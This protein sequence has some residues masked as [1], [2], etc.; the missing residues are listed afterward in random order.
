MQ[1]AH[2]VADRFPDGQLYLNLRG[3]HPSGKPVPAAA[4]VRGLLESLGVAAERI[5]AGVDA[6]ARLY[7]S[8]LAGRRMLVLLDNAKD[9]EQVRP[10]LPG[11]PGC[12]VLV[13]SRC[14]LS[15]LVAS[16]AGTPPPQARAD[17][18]E[19]ARAHLIS[20]LVPGRYAMHDLLRA[21]AAEQVAAGQVA[22]DQGALDRILDHYLHTA[23]VA[24]LRLRP[25]RDPITLAPPAPAVTI[26]R[27][28]SFQ[29]ALD[30]FDAEHHVLLSAVT[31]AAG[32]GRDACA[33]QL[34]WAMTDFL[35]WRGHWHDWA[36][37]QRVALSAAIR[38]GD[39][40]AE[41]AARLILGQ[42]GARSGNYDQASEHL[43]Q[44]LRLFRQLGDRAG[45][46]RTHQF[47]LYVAEHQARYADALSHA[48][49]ALAH[50]RAILS[51]LGQ[52]AAINDIGWCHA[53]LGDYQRA[54]AR[55]RQALALYRKLGDRRGEAHTWDSLGY[56]EHHLG[57]HAQA[58]V[59][60][61]HALSL[62]RELR[63]RFSEADVLTHLGDARAAVDPVGARD[64]WQQALDIFD[65][66]HHPRNAQVRAKLARTLDLPAWTPP[67]S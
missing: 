28:G 27:I 9:E 55:C 11:S 41:A 45:E 30:W 26:E 65:E 22:A 43:T 39:P 19:L 36:A 5:P 23:R 6:Q 63:D 1:W 59:C 40:A 46:A 33:W 14:Q 54:R 44:C 8:I 64:A 17:L 53:Q 7:R 58:A 31:L 18:R 62:A 57:R 67:A 56:A 38:L 25:F 51:P 42:A 32:S 2:Q 13:T 35:D 34:P 24:A 48:R 21:Y 37:T 52:A 49:H 60:Y 47:L 16:L 50:Y 20:E 3:F 15:G 66:L 61:Q 12:L 10:L 4:A 29:D